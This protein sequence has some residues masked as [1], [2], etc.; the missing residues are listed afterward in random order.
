MNTYRLIKNTAAGRLLLLIVLGAGTNGF[1]AE[2]IYRDLLGNTVPSEKCLPKDQAIQRA[3]SEF[4][5]KR[6]SKTF[7]ET[8]GYGWHTEQRKNEGTLVCHECGTEPGKHQCHVEDIQ[9]TC[10]RLKPGSAG[11]IPGKG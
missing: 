8:Q 7:C 11:L 10:K 9:V 2:F 5:L 1:A 3:T 6:F 4:E